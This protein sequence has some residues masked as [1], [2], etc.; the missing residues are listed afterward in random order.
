MKSQ[1]QRAASD[2]EMIEGGIA[3]GRQLSSGDVIALNGDLGAGKTHFCKGIALGF[4]FEGEV[5]SPTFSLVHEYR[6]KTGNIFHFDFYRVESVV[7][8]VDLGWD[9]YLEEDGV[10]V[11]EWANKFPEVFPHET[12]WFELTIADNGDHVVVEK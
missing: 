6:A 4:D 8:L 10:I 2:Q 7:E 11:V 12:R 9:D 1:F 5:T 3:L